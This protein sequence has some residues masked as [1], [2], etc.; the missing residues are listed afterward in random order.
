MR[1]KQTVEEKTNNAYI[2]FLEQQLP[3]GVLGNSEEKIL[4]RSDTVEDFFVD[5]EEKKTVKNT[6]FL[7][8]S[9]KYTN[10]KQ[11]ITKV[12]WEPKSIIVHTKEFYSWINSMLYGFFKDKIYYKPFALYQAQ[13]YRWLCDDN[14]PSRYD[15]EEQRVDCIEKN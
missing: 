1:H 4:E 3:K 9:L 7:Q 8:K 13:A 6:S 12:D 5:K 2:E 14:D 10:L 15:Y 11:D